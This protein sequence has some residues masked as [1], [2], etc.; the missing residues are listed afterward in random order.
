M[1]KSIGKESDMYLF[2]QIMIEQYHEDNTRKLSI[3]T[4][5]EVFLDFLFTLSVII[6]FGMVLMFLSFIPNILLKKRFAFLLAVIS[7]VFVFIVVFSF[8]VGMS[9]ITE[10]SLGSIQGEGMIDVSIPSGEKVYMDASWGLGVGFYTILIAASIS[11]GTAIY[12]IVKS[13]RE[14]LSRLLH[15][16]RSKK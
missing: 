15:S 3:A 2:P 9:S 13:Q 14:R 16:S 4:I 10:I 7:I 12:D 5:P 8:Y 6:G 11:L 1:D